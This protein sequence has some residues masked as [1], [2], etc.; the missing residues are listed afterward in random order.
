[1]KLKNYLKNTRGSK[2]TKLSSNIII[3]T[4]L[5]VLNLFNIKNCITVSSVLFKLLRRYNYKP[6]LFIGAN[7]ADKKLISHAWVEFEGNIYQGNPIN[8]LRLTKFLEIE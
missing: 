3:A 1:M 4:C 8:T 2:N 7:Y 5:K 6:K